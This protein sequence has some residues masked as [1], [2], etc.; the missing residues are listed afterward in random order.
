MWSAGAG[1][2]IEATE[3]ETPMVALGSLESHVRISGN[4]EA[5]VTSLAEPVRL[6]LEGRHRWYF[7]RIDDLGR[8]GEVLISITGSKGRLP[9]LFGRGELE[10]AHVCEVVE[11]AVEAVAL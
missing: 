10:P 8:V 11:D 6:A 1:V 4:D 3:E 5:L 2:A 9:L 7:V